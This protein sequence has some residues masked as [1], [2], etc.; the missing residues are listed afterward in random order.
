MQAAATY[1]SHG[2]DYVLFQVVWNQSGMLRGCI[3]MRTTQIVLFHSKN[4]N[5]FKS[6]SKVEGYAIVANTHGTHNLSLVLE[7]RHIRVWR[8]MI[9]LCMKMFDRVDGLYYIVFEFYKTSKFYKQ[10]KHFRACLKAFFVWGSSEYE[11][12]KQTETID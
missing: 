5:A 1:S 2:N 4:R 11:R 7:H 12:Q 10:Q 3:H 8:C 9:M 6:D